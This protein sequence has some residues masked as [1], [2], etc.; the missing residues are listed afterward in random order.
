MEDHFFKTWFLFSAMI[1]LGNL[2]SAQE[3]AD[4]AS[5]L[6]LGWSSLQTQPAKCTHTDTSSSE[7]NIYRVPHLLFHWAMT[8]CFFFLDLSLIYLWVTT[9]DSCKLIP[10]PVLLLPQLCSYRFPV[11]EGLRTPVQQA[12]GYLIMCLICSKML[13]SS[14]VFRASIRYWL[15][16][17]KNIS[18][19]SSYRP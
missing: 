1:S 10:S 14:V 2:L 4:S 12:A 9:P 7:N 6:C 8:L 5:W 13:F 17:S 3:A 18:F 15:N 11:T 19:P 16:S